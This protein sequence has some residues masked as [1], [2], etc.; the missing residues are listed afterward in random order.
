M[1]SYYRTINESLDGELTMTNA[2][3]HSPRTP[4]GVK[5]AWGREALW[6]QELVKRADRLLL[7][8]CRTA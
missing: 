8:N 1:N 7:R 6:G 4:G 5:A 3:D 2:W